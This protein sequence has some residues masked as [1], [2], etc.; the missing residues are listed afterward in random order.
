LVLSS[1]L[2]PVAQPPTPFPAD[3][4][5][6]QTAPTP[7]PTP[8]TASAATTSTEPSPRAPGVPLTILD[9]KK[10]A[11]LVRLS[12]PDVA[13]DL[14]QIRIVRTREFAPNAA[15][16][17]VTTG[18]VNVATLTPEGPMT[19]L[20]R[21]GL[22]FIF[23]VH[24][25]DH[26]GILDFRNA[27]LTEVVDQRNRPIYF[28]AQPDRPLTVASSDILSWDRTEAL[29]Q[30]NTGAPD[31]IDDK[32]ARLAGE[33]TVEVGVVRPVQIHD[34]RGKIGQPFLE[35]PG[36]IDLKV[37]MESFSEEQIVLVSEGAVKLLGE[38]EFLDQSDQP[39]PSYAKTMD[40][41]ALPDGRPRQTNTFSF[42]GLPGIIKL[43]INYYPTIETRELAIRYDDL[44]LP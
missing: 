16:A 24:C 23:R 42:F 21:P 41:E 26:C 43:R 34:L 19:N 33:M 3:P 25:P 11:E 31:R 29:I 22:A 40:V 38:F 39:I 30:F 7:W 1:V 14:Q 20:F 9:D 13:V 18:T 12:K 6:T 5:R 37:Q 4:R 2:S 44:P 36:G 8:A 15:G 32:L 27:R 10:L 35:N 28:E 17:G